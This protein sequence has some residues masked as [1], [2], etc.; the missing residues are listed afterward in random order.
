GGSIELRWL[1]AVNGDRRLPLSQT[2]TLYLGASLH[3]PRKAF[4]MRGFCTFARSQVLAV[5]LVL[6]I[7]GA[8]LGAAQQPVP[9]QAP[10]AILR[11]ARDIGAPNPGQTLHIAVSLQPG[12][13]LGLEQYANA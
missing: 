2:G 1:A 4:L 7:S 10:L 11:S 5:F 8:A 3:G 6:A 12:N 13:I 9:G